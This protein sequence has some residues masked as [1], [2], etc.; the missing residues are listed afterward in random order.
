MPRRGS[1]R[2]LARMASSNAILSGPMRPPL[3]RSRRMERRVS[4]IG[5]SPARP[6]H[7]DSINKH[8]VRK[9]ELDSRGPEHYGQ[10]RPERSRPNDVAL[11]TCPQA[12]ACANTSLGVR[13][14]SAWCGRSLL[15][16]TSHA[17]I[18]RRVSATEPYALMNTSSLQAA[19]QPFN[20]DVVEEPALAVHATAHTTTFPL[21]EK[22]STGELYALIWCTS[23][24]PKRSIASCRASMLS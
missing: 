18:P 3:E 23:G 15:Q 2:P 14:S 4:V 7:Q 1:N 13:W 8:L 9:Q 6:I 10:N 12:F 20:E 22:R 21:I 17:P 11:S 5:Q 19:P 24:W 16:N